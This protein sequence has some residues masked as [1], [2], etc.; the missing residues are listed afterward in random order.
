MHA[1]R[2]GP[3]SSHDRRTRAGGG[4]RDRARGWRAGDRDD[5]HAAA[6]DGR[7]R[8]SRA[9]A[10]AAVPDDPV[11]ELRPP[12]TPVPRRR[13]GSPTP[14]ASGTSRSRASSAVLGASRATDGVGLYLVGRRRRAGRDRARLVGRDGRDAARVPR[15][16]ATSR[17]SRGRAT[18][19][20]RRRS[21][22][23]L[24]RRA[25]SSTSG[26]AFVPAGRRLPADA[27]R[28]APARHLGGQARRAALLPPRG[29]TL[30]SRT[31]RCA[32]S[33]RGSATSTA[34]RGRRRA[35]ADAARARQADGRRRARALDATIEP[36]GDVGTDA[37]RGGPRAISELSR[38]GCER[39]G[40]R[41]RAARM[42]CCASPSTAPAGRRSRR[43]SATSSGPARACNPFDSLPMRRRARTARCS[44]AS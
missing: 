20:S 5:R 12:R 25:W 31:S 14:T 37:G 11:L 42:R 26:D 21:R 23:F 2:R 7:P 9:A 43:R 30:R 22:V 3:P 41:R 10:R 8:A 1:R 24:R 19:S 32:P 27:L 38:H 28:A 39:R 35:A 17:C 18:T 13:A 40:P 29:A 34:R 33:S 4:H 36:A 44:A 6:R 16:R 15:R